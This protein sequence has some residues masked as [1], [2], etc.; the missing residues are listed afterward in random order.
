VPK[1]R[2]SGVGEGGGGVGAGLGGPNEVVQYSAT[3]RRDEPMGVSAPQGISGDIFV[4]S[5]SGNTYRVNIADPENAT[6]TCPDHIYHRRDCRHILGALS[7]V[8]LASSGVAAPEPA[9]SVV[10]RAVY[11][12]ERTDELAAQRLEESA[13][14]TDLQP[15]PEH[16][17]E[18]TADSALFRDLYQRARRGEF[19]YEY[20]NV[21]DGSNNTFGVELEFALPDVSTRR[22][23]ISRIARDLYDAG[24]IN[25][26]T[27][28]GYHSRRIPGLWTFERDGSVNGGELVS[29][30]F[31]DTPE[32]WRQIEQVCEIIQRHGGIVNSTCGAHVSIGFDPIDHDATR[33]RNLLR[34]CRANEDLLYR[35]ASGGESNGRHRGTSYARPLSNHDNVINAGNSHYDAMNRDSRRIE[36]RYFNGTLSPKQ[37]QANVRLA[38]ALVRAAGRMSEAQDESALGDAPLGAM[39]DAARRNGE[40][41]QHHT[42]RAFLDRIF[43]RTQDKLSVL[44][45]YATSKW[46]T[47]LRA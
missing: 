44:W 29:P 37:I 34:F 4:S 10:D 5:R 17:V 2:G 25:T 19:E 42:A 38:H 40:R 24:L 15:L 27:Q 26:P 13:Q 46:Q 45:L 14:L 3:R 12:V 6:C 11:E 30:V 36:M 43:T 23:A 39:R 28:Q 8:G 41:N 31:R 16:E 22:E 18:L 35:L 32:A 1:R 9:T 20:E 47:Q 21:L 7:A 33:W